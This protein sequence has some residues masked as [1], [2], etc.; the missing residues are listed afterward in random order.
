MISSHNSYIYITRKEVDQS[1]VAMNYV[2]SSY[3]DR[4]KLTFKFEVVTKTLINVLGLSSRR[5]V[6]QTE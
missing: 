1:T 6:V 2:N 4:Y 5:V 3:I